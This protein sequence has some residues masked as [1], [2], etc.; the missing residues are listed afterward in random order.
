MFLSKNLAPKNNNNPLINGNRISA[1]ED[2]F[3]LPLL[4][5][6]GTRGRR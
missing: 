5:T 6:T 3:E 2:F 4:T 1:Q